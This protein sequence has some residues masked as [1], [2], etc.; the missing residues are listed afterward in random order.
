M[1]GLENEIDWS[2][3][4]CEKVWMYS[5]KFIYNNSNS[6][7]RFYQ[8]TNEVFFDKIA[9]HISDSVLYKGKADPPSKKP[10]VTV[11][12]KFLDMFT[13]EQLDMYNAGM[14]KHAQVTAWN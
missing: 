12:T 13:I 11:E 14:L 6:W 9:E 4:S 2:K 3:W 5:Q 8:I 7:F 1:N 10:A